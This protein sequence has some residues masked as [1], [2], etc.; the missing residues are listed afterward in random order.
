MSGVPQRVSGV[1]IE[2]A[3]DEWV[4]YVQSSNTAHALNASA[5]AL[6]NAIDGVR[7]VEALA[8]LLDVDLDVV[9]L[10][11]GELVEAGLVVVEGEVG[12][13]S[14]RE[15]L[16]KI[17]IGTAA[18]AALPVVETI[19]APSRAAASSLPPR[20]PRPTDFPT[21]GP[22]PSP[23]HFPAPSPRPTPQPSPAP[24]AYPAPSPK[25][26]PQPSPAPSPQPTPQPSPAPSP[27]PTPQPSPAPSPQPTPQPSPAPTP[28]QTDN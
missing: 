12:R 19:V 22:T 6:F 2:V 3:G 20:T 21:P 23:Q 25:P 18:A 1:L 8:S 11:L 24:H 7:S 15:L 28:E 16:R 27:Q 13:S 10:G 14:R 26:T 4:A 5:G 17:G 9:D